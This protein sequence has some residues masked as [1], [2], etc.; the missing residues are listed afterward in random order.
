VCN[1]N[2]F[3]KFIIM[4]TLFVKQIPPDTSRNTPRNNPFR[5]FCDRLV[6]WVFGKE[7]YKNI[8]RKK[9]QKKVYRGNPKGF[10]V[11]DFPKIPDD[12]RLKLIEESISYCITVS[13]HPRVLAGNDEVDMIL[14]GQKPDRREEER[15]I[16]S[17]QFQEKTREHESNFKKIFP[18]IDQYLDLFEEKLHCEVIDI[19]LEEEKDLPYELEEIVEES[20]KLYL[21]KMRFLKNQIDGNYEK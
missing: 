21:A 4:R 12:V 20:Y 11:P 3:G 16:L 1:P 14:R 5:N 7:I 17:D 9:P 13:S 2:L 15:K 10:S 19:G 18:P 8:R 6:F